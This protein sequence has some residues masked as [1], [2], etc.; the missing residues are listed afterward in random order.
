M[1]NNNYIPTQEQFQTVIDNLTKAAKLYPEG[2]IAMLRLGISSGH[3]CLTPMCHAGW[4]GF[5]CGVSGHSYTDGGELMA[6]HLGF[7]FNGEHSLKGVFLLEEWAAQN[8]K[9]WGNSNGVGIFSSAEAFGE[10]TDTLISLWQIVNHW[11]GV[12]ERALAFSTEE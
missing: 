8:E 10:T 5:I 1:K 7:S 12:K 4:Y 2:K 11:K 6:E 3:G 9:I